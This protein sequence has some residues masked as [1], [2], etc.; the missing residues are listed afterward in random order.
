VSKGAPGDVHALG[1]EHAFAGQQEQAEAVLQRLLQMSEQRYVPS[2][3]IGSAHLALG[4]LD[5]GFAWLE[6]AHSERDFYL[7]Y[8]PIDPRL[9]GVRGD[10]RFTDLLRRISGRGE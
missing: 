3:F 6:R 4:R 10:S 5:E 8:L 9:S 1:Q 7:V 2:F